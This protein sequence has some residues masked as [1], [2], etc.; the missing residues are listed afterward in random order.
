MPMRLT[1]AN[2]RD[3]LS[4]EEVVVDFS[5]D[6]PFLLHGPS[7]QCYVTKTDLVRDFGIGYYVDVFYNKQSKYLRIEI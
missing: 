4:P 3:Y 6:T 2:D 7:G 5:I 1:P